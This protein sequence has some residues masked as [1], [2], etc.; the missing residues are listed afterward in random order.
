MFF[1][2]VGNTQLKRIA[3]YLAVKH[4]INNEQNNY[5]ND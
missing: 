5:E 2:M 4:T 1:V 3:F